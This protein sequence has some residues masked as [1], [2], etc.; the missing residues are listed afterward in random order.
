MARFD[1]QI[2]L[3]A[4]EAGAL[5]ADIN[6]QF[7]GQAEE[8]AQIVVGGVSPPVIDNT[9]TPQYTPAKKQRMFV[10]L[11]IAD[12]G[13]ARDIKLVLIPRALVLT[14]SDY[15]N[16]RFP[17]HLTSEITDDI[18]G[19][20]L[21]T[22]PLSEPLDPLTQYDIILAIA[23][24]GNNRA[25]NP[26]PDPTYAGYPANVLY[27]FTTPA[28]A[29]DAGVPSKP[30]LARLVSNTVDPNSDGSFSIAT[31]RIFAD[32]TQTKTFTQQNTV[33]VQ[34]KVVDSGGGKAPAPPVSIEDGT[35]TFVDDSIAG[36]ITGNPY[37]WSKNTASDSEGQAT[38][39]AAGSLTFIA[40]GFAD[41]SDS[42]AN[43]TLVSA[44]FVTTEDPNAIIVTFTLHQ[45][46]PS[47]KLKNYTAKRKVS[48][49]PDS[50]YDLPRNLVVDRGD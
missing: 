44:N 26:S 34:P 49:N 32:E 40:G 20:Q 45:P 25:F 39:S 16:L 37:T 28:Q 43:L 5:I 14:S 30:T 41:P 4:D 35:L 18:I 48:A 19:L 12:F 13:T 27:T 9:F 17:V 36:L 10:T 11:R 7:A 33:S 21:I 22:S 15:D 42:L 3:R 6:A 2:G 31:M 47:Y 29:S 8:T 50:D 1:Q 38:V 46:T 24:E 23:I